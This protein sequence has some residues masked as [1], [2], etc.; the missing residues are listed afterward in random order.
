MCGIVL[1][2]DLQQTEAMLYII[3]HR[4]RDDRQIVS[5]D[6]IHLGFNR[7]S[8]MVLG[9]EGK[10]PVED[11]RSILAFNGEIYNWRDLRQGLKFAPKKESE[12]GVVQSLISQFP[13]QFFRFLDGS[14]ALVYVDKGRKQIIVSRDFLGIIP[15][16]RERKGLGI[17]SEKKA[18][19]DPVPIRAG[20]TLWLN[21][22]GKVLRRHQQDYYSLHVAD[23]DHGHIENLFRFAVIRR[24]K[25]AERPVCI[26]LSGGIDSA[27][28]LAVAKDFNKDI[29][30]VT[31][32]A[33]AKSQEAE[34]AVRLCKEWNV[35][36]KLVEV[37]P[38]TWDYERMKYMLDDPKGHLSP[39]RWPPFV[40]LY[41]AAQHA[42]GDIILCG[43]GADEIGGGYRC[44]DAVQGLEREWKRLS[45]LLSMPEINLD[46]TNISGL[47]WTKEYRTPF[48]D[49]ALVLY[50]MG[51]KSEHS[52]GVIR[53]LAQRLGVPD[54][55]LN[56]PKFTTEEPAL[57]ATGQPQIK[58]DIL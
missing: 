37:D 35:P 39:V 52:K 5:F 32:V 19:K 36:H 50:L 38:T 48:L 4:G 51:C 12:A 45:T 31:V 57:L 18:L 21:F 41:L 43:E 11:E 24:L 40:R 34:N 56:K 53:T 6:G 15:I 10:Q 28:I 17:A 3:Q 8:L 26:A 29:Q 23:P 13:K 2:K 14:Y 16:Y 49:K 25:H 20:E 22:N 1:S 54:Y 7:L 9:N 30:A 58:Q 33:D 55:I 44:H 42:P 47:A 46:R 27:C